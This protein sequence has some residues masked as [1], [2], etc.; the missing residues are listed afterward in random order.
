M[1]S[2]PI[3]AALPPMSEDE[4]LAFADEQSLKY[5]YSGKHRRPIPMRGES[6]QHGIIRANVVGLLMAWLGERH[7]SVISGETRVYSS[8][9]NAYRYPDVAMFCGEPSYLNNRRD[10]LSNPVLIAEVASSTTLGM[11]LEEKFHDYIAMDSVQL[12]VLILENKPHVHSYQRQ[13]TTQWIY[14]AADT[15]EA[16]LHVDLF[17]SPMLLSLAQIYRRIR[18]DENDPNDSDT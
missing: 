7:C 3:D 15:V 13:T 2:N 4:Y 16:Q 9:R 10:T 6:I 14:R 17:Y 8:E 11:D 5:E 1:Q 18:W 12:Y